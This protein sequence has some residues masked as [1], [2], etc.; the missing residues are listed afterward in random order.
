MAYKNIDSA[1]TGALVKSVIK[2]QPCDLAKLK[3]GDIL[4]GIET[5]NEKGATVKYKID[6]HGQ[7][8]FCSTEKKIKF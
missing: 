1:F 2:G 5:K 4:M 7:V 6:N 3:P 8:D